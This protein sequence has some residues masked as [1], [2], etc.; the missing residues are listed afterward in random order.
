MRLGV[1]GHVW[2]LLML[3]LAGC[4]L[5]KMAVE[6]TL[7]PVPMWQ[8]ASPV[9][10]GICFE[11]AFDAAGQVFVLR[12]SPALSDLYDLADNSELCRQPVA[13]ETFDFRDG[14][15]LVGLWSQGNGCTAEHEVIDM[16]RYTA[17][18]IISLRLRFT[19]GGTCPYELVRPFWIALPDAADY[20]IHIVME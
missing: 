18:R 13:R 6:P 5:P 20:E 15:V 16:E 19:T 11:A 12:D 9:M 1:I 7:T 14:R 17:Q 8:D 10:A 2:L 4:T 3:L